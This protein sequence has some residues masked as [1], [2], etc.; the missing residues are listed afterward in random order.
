MLEHN[1]IYS[2]FLGNLS[3]QI[4]WLLGI[5]HHEQIVVLSYILSAIVLLCLIGH[6]LCKALYQ[7]KILQQLNKKELFRE[8]K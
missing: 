7:K 5:L 4:D 6:T 1:S 3:Q 8:E 2:G